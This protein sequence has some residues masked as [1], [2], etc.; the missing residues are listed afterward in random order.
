[1]M[2][3]EE[4]VA[5]HT[6]VGGLAREDSEHVRLVV[7]N[8]RGTAEADGFQPRTERSNKPLKWWI[9]TV[10]LSI[11]AI[12]VLIVF[13]KWGV[14]FIFEKVYIY[15]YSCLMAFSVV[16]L[17]IPDYITTGDGLW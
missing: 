9:K 7:S 12:V 6:S 11:I 15:P 17:Y 3:S 16:L 5:K 13:L 1:M 4:D 14:P 10:T 8:E 2:V